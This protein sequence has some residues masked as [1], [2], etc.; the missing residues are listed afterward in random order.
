[1]EVENIDLIAKLRDSRI[2]TSR[3]GE[4]GVAGTNADPLFRLA[5]ICRGLIKNGKETGK[6]GDA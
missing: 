3:F 2:A 1:M 6:D 4:I 5:D